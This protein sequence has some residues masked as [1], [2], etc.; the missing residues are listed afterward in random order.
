MKGIFLDTVGLLGLWDEDDQWHSPAS[1]AFEEMSLHR[2]PLFT[3]SFIIAECANA[4]AR[5]IER[6]KIA[7]LVKSLQ[8]IG[9]FIFPT[10]D[11]WNLAW[12]RYTNGSPGGPGLVDHLSF[13]VMQRLGLKRAFTNDRHFAAFEFEPLF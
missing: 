2:E 8:A 7:A 5:W 3:T 1:R 9:G 10:D 4:T 11:D 6:E 13:A 12:V